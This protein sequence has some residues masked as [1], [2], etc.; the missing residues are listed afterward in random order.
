MVQQKSLGVFTAPAPLPS[1]IRDIYNIPKI[2]ELAPTTSAP[3]KPITNVEIELLELL[4][5]LS[6][7]FLGSTDLHIIMKEVKELL[8]NKKYLICFGTKEIYRLAYTS[9]WVPSRALIYR[10]IMRESK[11]IKELLLNSL[12]GEIKTVLCLGGG[13]GSE[14][15]ALGSLLSKV[16]EEEWNLKGRIE[17]IAVDNC[18]WSKVLKSQEEAMLD[19]YSDLEGQ[20]K[21]SF[22]QSDILTSNSPSTSTLTSTSTSTSTIEPTPSIS[23]PSIS[24]LPV[25]Y[26]KAS[27][28][29]LLF[30]ISEL[31]LQSRLLTLQLLSTL[32]NSTQ[33]GTLLLIVE[34]ASLAQ[35][36]I[37]NSGRTHALTTLLDYTLIEDGIGGK[38]ASWKKLR[39]EESIWYRMPLGAEEFYPTKLENSRVIIRLYER[40]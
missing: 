33:S 4:S 38:R 22:L 17:V 16:K 27:L 25:P 21:V 10:K 6:A 7:P 35:V 26:E 1:R 39:E 31:F 3:I 8:F 12:P 29:T 18:D 20:F 11:E 13:A 14:V 19:N 40:L 2:V 30:T 24:N 28:I 36:S 37:G 9:R 34:S 23:S 5:K 15:L 32:S